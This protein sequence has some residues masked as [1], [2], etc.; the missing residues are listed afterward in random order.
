[1]FWIGLLN[2]GKFAYKHMTQ[3]LQTY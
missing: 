2:V 1:L 3:L